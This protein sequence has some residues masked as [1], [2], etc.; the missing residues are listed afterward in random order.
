MELVNCTQE[1]WEFVRKLRMDGRVIDGFVE[2]IPIT[3]EQQTAYMTNNSQYYRM[4]Q[5]D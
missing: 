1:F 5:G 4:K 2:T 3:P